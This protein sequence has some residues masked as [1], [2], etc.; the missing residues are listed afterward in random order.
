MS[1]DINKRFVETFKKN[2]DLAITFAR[3]EDEDTEI[4]KVRER[5]P[6]AFPW[7]RRLKEASRVESVSYTHLTLPTILLV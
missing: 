1:R 7:N 6:Y 2:N 3:T 5:I 4:D